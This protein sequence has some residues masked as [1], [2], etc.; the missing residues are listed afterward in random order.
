MYG[1]R[2]SEIVNATNEALRLCDN[3]IKSLQRGDAMALPEMIVMAFRNMVV[4]AESGDVP[5]KCRDLNIAIGKLG[6]ELRQYVMNYDGKVNPNG[7]PVGS[8]WNAVYGI[9]ITVNKA[10]TVYVEQLESIKELYEQKVSKDQIAFHI[11][12]HTYR[13]PA[14]G[15]FSSKGPFVTEHGIVN[16][17]LLDQ[18]AQSLEAQEL[19]LGKDWYPPWKQNIQSNRQKETASRLQAFKTL[20]D[21]PKKNFDSRSIEQMLLEGC[22]VQQIEKYKGVSRNEVLDECE[23]LGITPTNEPGWTAMKQVQQV[24]PTVPEHMQQLG[25][26][27]IDKSSGSPSEE[28]FYDESSGNVKIAVIAC[29]NGNP[30]YGPPE[31][32]AELAQDGIATNNKQVAQII[33]HLKKEQKQSE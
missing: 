27:N 23:R 14:T 16:T 6:E 26:Q 2:Q 1:D 22:Y 13:N 3:W 29:M 10:D 24:K 33:R 18:A 12:G 5:D 30:G 4:V 9:E 21:G 28:G 17:K 8:F 20:S 32:V 25:Q 31:I 11:Y 19:I 15:Q 7:S